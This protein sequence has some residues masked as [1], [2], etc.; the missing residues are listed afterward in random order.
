MKR[1]LTTLAAALP[2]MAGSLAENGYRAHFWVPGTYEPGTTKPFVW[3]ALCIANSDAEVRPTFTSKTRTP[4]LKAS[5]TLAKRSMNRTFTANAGRADETLRILSHGHFRPICA[6]LHGRRSSRTGVVCGTLTVISNYFV[7][8]TD[9]PFETEIKDWT[10]DDKP[11]MVTTS[12][13]QLAG[14]GPEEVPALRALI[15]KKIMVEGEVFPSHARYHI[16][17]LLIDVDVEAGGGFFEWD[18]EKTEEQN[19][20]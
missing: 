16:E 18:F 7:V 15:G 12:E 6:G 13:I 20:K 9:H 11:M 17:A 1:L 2:F 3:H 10:N 4:S 14:Y 8:K 5:N 19:N